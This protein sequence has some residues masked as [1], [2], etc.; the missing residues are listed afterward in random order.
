VED[1]QQLNL[2]NMTPIKCSNQG[3]DWRNS[4]CFYA[5]GSRLVFYSVHAGKSYANPI[6][7]H[8]SNPKPNTNPNPTWCRLIM[9]RRIG[10]HCKHRPDAGTRRRKIW[11]RTLK[12]KLRRHRNFVSKYR[13]SWKWRRDRRPSSS[14]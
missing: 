9:H 8:K 2:I 4:G 3:D 7:K 11:S 10:G 13:V 14:K 6:T 5:S 1:T 12:N